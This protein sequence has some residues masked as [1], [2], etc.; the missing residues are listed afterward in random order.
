MSLQ[1]LKK[2]WPLLLFLILYVLLSLFT[3]KSYGVTNDE[4][5][6]Y[7][8]GKLLYTKILAND[9][10][11]ERSF[12]IDD[13]KSNL[14]RYDR[15]YQAVLYSFNETE[16]F[17]TYHLLNLL[18][19]S[20]IFIVAYELFLKSSKNKYLALIGPLLILLTPRFF[21]H[22]AANPK[23]VPFAIAYFLALSAII[24]CK[25]TK[26]A[27][28][29]L[30]LGLSFGFAQS[31]RVIGY[32]IYLVFFTYQLL[33]IKEKINLKK[34]FQLIVE[35][36]IIFC[37]GFLINLLTLPY[38]AAD[39]L[40]NFQELLSASAKF[41]WSGDILFAGKIY[42]ANNLPWYYLPTWIAISTP[43][44]ILFLL[45]HS[46]VNFKKWLKIEKLFW[47]SI[48]INLIIFYL[49]K[50]I[51]YDGL[52]HFLFLLP[53]LAS[54]A[55]LALLR[56][57]KKK[58]KIILTLVAINLLIVSWQI[59][60]LFPYQYTY[61]NE[62][63]GGTKG[64]DGRY[65][66]D[67]WGASYREATLWLNEHTDEAETTTVFTCGDPAQFLNYAT[68][69][70][71][72]VESPENADLLICHKRADNQSILDQFPESIFQVSRSGVVLN[73]VKGR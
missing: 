48:T 13:G 21:G 26:Q 51:I 38:L 12:V 50:P 39:P 20:L 27:F 69:N 5:E 57:I 37:L 40:H 25:N 18:F 71:V 1:F 49:L 73:E 19:A 15:I 42:Q 28:S 8:L 34:I 7:F 24:F 43:L 65:E 11:L 14:Y 61:F 41:P 62:L 32:S 35:I 53:I 2:R 36:L 55:G 52:R 10:V 64:A 54:L 16:S 33:L 6:E 22:I 70:F 17:A 9:P 72:L 66:L 23:D 58:Q 59:I 56:I 46:L 60:K 63:V 3:Y 67:Y 47:L 30:M 31:L 45:I 68:D 29:L 44:S 4:A